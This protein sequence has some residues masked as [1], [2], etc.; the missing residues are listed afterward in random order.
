MLFIYFFQKPWPFDECLSV[1]RRE[2]T[3][4]ISY[5][6]KQWRN[7][8]RRRDRY[9]VLRR[10]QTLQ[11][12][13]LHLYRIDHHSCDFKALDVYVRNIVNAWTIA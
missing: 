3:E 10:L 4:C 8:A 6:L 5:S 2:I 9:R 1:L 13:Y 11:R 12:L 7:I